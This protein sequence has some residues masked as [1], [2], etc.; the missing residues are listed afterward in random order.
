MKLQTFVIMP[1]GV[2]L[3]CGPS[4]ATPGDG[5]TEPTVRRQRPVTRSGR[6]PVYRRTPRRPTPTRHR[7]RRPTPTSSRPAPPALRAAVAADSCAA[8][9]P[10][11]PATTVGLVLPARAALPSRPA[12]SLTPATLAPSAFL[13]RPSRPATRRAAAAPFAVLRHPSARMRCSA[14]PGTAKAPSR[15]PMT[16]ATA[17]TQAGMA[18]DR[19]GRGCSR[20]GCRGPTDRVC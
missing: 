3:A 6:P 13:A 8:I 5:S 9:L 7:K 4:V 19:S 11:I 1:L 2:T 14:S 10:P 16:S 15:P 18:A 20:N 12:S 17:P